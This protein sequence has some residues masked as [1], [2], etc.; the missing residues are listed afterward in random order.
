[1]IPQ[2]INT[3]DI[4]AL[5]SLNEGMGRVLVEAM[6]MGKPIVASDIGGIPD[7]VKDGA[8]GILFT[9]RDVD[10]MAEAIIK[11]LLDRELRR[12]MGNEGKKLAYPAYD[13][14]VMV[15]K[16]EGLYKDLLKEKRTSTFSS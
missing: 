6:A 12:K 10:A 9:P 5:P 13:A 1:D 15:R 14:S 7:L 3:F 4:F 2:L 11:L 8:N 16:I